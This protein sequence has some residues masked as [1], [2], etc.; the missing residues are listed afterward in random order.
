MA[1]YF[2]QS[3]PNSTKQAWL[4]SVSLCNSCYSQKPKN[5]FRIFAGERVCM[6]C[7]FEKL[8]ENQL[9]SER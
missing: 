2:Y 7:W 3:N 1:T 5:E 4:G 8:E 6:E 9:I